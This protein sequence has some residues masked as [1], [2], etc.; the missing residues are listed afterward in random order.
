MRRRD[1][2]T[3]LGG[4]AVA[5][6]LA[7]HAQQPEAMRRRLDDRQGQARHAA[8]PEAQRVSMRTLRPSV[9]PNSV[10]PLNECGGRRLPMWCA[11][12]EYVK[13]RHSYDPTALYCLTQAALLV[14]RQERMS[15]AGHPSPRTRSPE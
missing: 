8:L 10:S 14:G 13:M 3:L 11:T 6:P 7:A 2:I 9:Q 1:F 12:F 5:L 4:A 15:L